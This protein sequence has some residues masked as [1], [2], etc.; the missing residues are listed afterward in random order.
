M[1]TMFPDISVVRYSLNVWKTAAG[2]LVIINS[3]DEADPGEAVSNHRF[4]IDYES[5]KVDDL[6]HIMQEIYG[7][8]AAS[9]P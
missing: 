7:E 4:W 3:Y 2:W 1:D 9:T 8:V 6:L 5:L